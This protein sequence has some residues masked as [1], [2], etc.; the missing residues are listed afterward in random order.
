MEQDTNLRNLMIAA[1]AVMGIMLFW[2]IFVW[3]PQN[4][5]AQQAFE[6]EQAQ[7]AELEAENKPP[8]ETAEVMPVIEEQ[9]RADVRV[10]FDGPSMDGSILLRGARVDQLSLKQ[11]FRTLDDKEAGLPEGEV[12]IF[13]PQVQAQGQDLGF[14]AFLGWRVPDQA[15]L[16]DQNTNWT[17][18]EGDR[19]TPDSPITLGV[20]RDGLNFSRKVEI[21]ENYMF[22]FTDTV[23]NTGSGEVSL[24]PYGVLREIGLPEDDIAMESRKNQSFILHQGFVAASGQELLMQGF[25]KMAKGKDEVKQ[26]ATNGGW[27]GLTTKYWLGAIVPDQDKPFTIFNTTRNTDRG[28]EFWARYEGSVTSLQPGQSTQSVSR[29]F[30]GAKEAKVLQAYEKDLGI[31]RFQDAIDW[32][33]MF[34]WL[35]KPFFAV[36]TFINGYVGN[37]G[38]SILLLTVLVKLVFFPIQYR[39]YQS[40]AKMRELTEPMKAIRESVEDKQEQQRQIMELYKERKVNPVAGCLP[41]LLQ[42][43][44]FYGLYK[45]LFVTIEMRHEPFIGYIRDLSA[46][47]PTA[48]GNLFGLLPIPTETIASIPLLSMVLVIGILP[49]FYGVTMW[50]LQSLNPP[51]PDETQR[52]IFGLMPIMFTFIFANFM[53]GLVIYWTWSNI[54]SI[55]QQYLIM[56]RSGVKTQLD[57]FIEAKLGKGKAEN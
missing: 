10:P 11:H 9:I 36:L 48:I 46:P 40:M 56:R 19:L 12:Q 21:D 41:L 20:S 35:T 23:T 45:T 51:P 39:A 30:G 2:Q 38:V 26:I 47:D 17:L 3:G 6:A 33:S 24:L 44:V 27:I 43:P 49:I 55:A 14:Y 4:K 1:A 57:K 34:F 22:T 31:P 29:V 5:A 54:L 18:V 16:T 52:L 13:H 53:V 8:T 50:A 28:Q 7:K 42:M 25:K 15:Y 32:G 37:F